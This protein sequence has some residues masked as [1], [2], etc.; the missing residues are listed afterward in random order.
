[1]ERDIISILENRNL[2][3]IE[4][5]NKLSDMG[6]KG[7]KRKEV[8]RNLYRMEREGKLRHE[9]QPPVWS[10]IENKNFWDKIIDFLCE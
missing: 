9:N 7:L 1:M 10:I 8:N 2:T 3:A 5:R 6:Y 4:I